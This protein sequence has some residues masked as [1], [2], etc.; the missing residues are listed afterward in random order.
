MELRLRNP[1]NGGGRR[2]VDRVDAPILPAIHYRGH[3]FVRRAHRKFLNRECGER[4]RK[5]VSFPL[6][7]RARRRFREFTCEVSTEP[8]GEVE[9]LNWCFRHHS[10]V[11]RIVNRGRSELFCDS[12]ASICEIRS[13][14]CLS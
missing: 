12:F 5:K 3:R 6:I 1:K 4:T 8:T 10:T 9:N 11:Q 13:S 14:R 2:K 7:S